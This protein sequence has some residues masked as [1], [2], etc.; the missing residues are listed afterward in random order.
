MH[1]FVVFMI[2]RR[3]TTAWAHQ[4]YAFLNQPVLDVQCPLPPQVT[5]AEPASTT[6]PAATSETK[7][8][9]PPAEDTKEEAVVTEDVAAPSAGASSRLC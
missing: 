3:S 4:L 8:N 6:V 1:F 7:T 5:A 2:L 9:A